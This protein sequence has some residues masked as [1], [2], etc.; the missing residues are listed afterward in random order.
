MSYLDATYNRPDNSLT[1][2]DPEL[3]LKSVEIKTGNRVLIAAGAGET[4]FSFLTTEASEVVAL[5]SNPIEGY[6]V[7]LKKAAIQEF[8][9]DDCME[10]LGFEECPVRLLMYQHLEDKISAEAKEYWG[11]HLSFIDQGI[12]H[13]GDFEHYLHLFNSKVLPIIHSSKTTLQLFETKSAEEQ[14]VFYNNIWK[15]RLWRLFFTLYF[16]KTSFGKHPHFDEFSA[17][18]KRNFSDEIY[19]LTENHL[20][21]IAA[22]NNEFL[23]YMLTGSFGKNLPFFI[24]EENYNRIKQNLS[25]LTIVHSAVDE[26]LVNDNDFTFIH[27]GE[28]IESIGSEEFKV[29]GKQLNSL[30]KKGTTVTHWNILSNHSLAEINSSEFS[31]D[32]EFA[33]SIL[34]QDK[35]FFHTRFNI[36]KKLVD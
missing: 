10:F 21:S 22:Q 19:Q 18:N 27:L 12:I 1:W 16:S 13:C 36:E 6:V 4:V 17:L 9:Q 15:S 35:C 20:S 3:V 23:R 25:R 29:F 26:Y 2:E 34:D 7:E 33:Q 14:Q 5:I 11:E 30:L 8:E 24:R 28:S 31:S 32:K